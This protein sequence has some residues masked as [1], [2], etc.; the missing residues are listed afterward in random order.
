MNSQRLG[1]NY[2]KNLRN[3]E[4][5]LTLSVLA[6]SPFKKRTHFAFNCTRHM[7][8]THREHFWCVP[9]SWRDRIPP[10]PSPVTVAVIEVVR[11]WILVDIV[12]NLP[13]KMTHPACKCKAEGKKLIFLNRIQEQQNR[14]SQCLKKVNR[15]RSHLSKGIL[16]QARNRQ[17]ALISCRFSCFLSRKPGNHDGNFSSF[18]SKSTAFSRLSQQSNL[19]NNSPALWWYRFLILGEARFDQL[20]SPPRTH[21]LMTYLRECWRQSQHQRASPMIE[22]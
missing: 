22:Q 2:K 13:T 1:E 18:W 11:V 12:D 8:I 15:C 9:R 10:P 17:N 5:L 20:P 4:A 21:R 3:E 7:P 16:F 6:S 19:L 14:Q